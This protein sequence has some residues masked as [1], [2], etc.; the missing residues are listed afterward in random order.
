[1]VKKSPFGAKKKPTLWAK[2]GTFQLKEGLGLE[3]TFLYDFFW[4]G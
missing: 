3:H 2:K 1:L 4:A